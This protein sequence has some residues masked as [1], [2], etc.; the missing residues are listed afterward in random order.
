[1][2]LI[3]KPKLNYAFSKIKNLKKIKKRISRKRSDKKVIIKK[4]TLKGTELQKINIR[5]KSFS[6]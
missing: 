2:A 3:T 4:R 6:G 1:M 5:N